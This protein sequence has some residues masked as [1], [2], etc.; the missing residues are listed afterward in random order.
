MK[1]VFKIWLALLCPLF[2]IASA[3]PSLAFPSE[4][5]ATGTGTIIGCEGDPVS[6]TANTN[7]QALAE[8]LMAGDCYELVPNSVVLKG[9]TGTFS[10]GMDA[11]GMDEGVI[12]SNASFSEIEGSNTSTAK[13]DD[14]NGAGDVDVQALTGINSFDAASIE[15]SFIPK[16]NQISFQ[17]VFASEEYCDKVGDFFSDGMGVYIN[18]E[19]VSGP[20]SNNRKNMAIVPGTANDPILINSINYYTNNQ[21]YISNIPSNQSQQGFGCDPSEVASTPYAPDLTQFDG[22]T[23]VLTATQTV[24]PG[25]TYNIKFVVADIGD[26]FGASAMMIKAGSFVTAA[27]VAMSFQSPTNSNQILENCMEEDATLTFERGGDLSAA[28]NVNINVSGTAQMNVDYESIPSNIT[29]PAGM[30]SYTLPIK[31]ITDNIIDDNETIRIN[32]SPSCNPNNNLEITIKDTPLLELNLA[33]ETSCTSSHASI[34]S[35]V[36]GG[37]PPY[38]YAWST[39]ATSPNITLN[40]SNANNNQASLTVTDFCGISINQSI[41]VEAAGLKLAFDDNYQ[42]TCIENSLTITPSQISQGN[43]IQYQW[44]STNGTIQGANNT[45]SIQVQTAGEYKL[46]ITDTTN[47]C[48]AEESVQ[49]SQN[50]DAPSAAISSSSNSIT[51]V[52][53][54]IQLSA[55]SDIAPVS[56]EWFCNGQAFSN[57]Q[58]IT[59]FNACNYQ[60]IVTNTNTGCTA[61]TSKTIE[62]NNDIPDLQAN[63]E[64]LLDCQND[65]VQLNAFS[66]TP[67]VSYQWTGAN[68]FNSNLPNPSIQIAG[69]Y[70]VTVSQDNGCTAS[71]CLE[72]LENVDIPNLNI[73]STGTVLTCDRTEIA[74]Y[75]NTPIDNVTYEWICNGQNISNDIEIIADQ[76]CTYQVLITNMD[77]GCTSM[78]STTINDTRSEP[79]I[80]AVALSALDCNNPSVQLQSSSNIA[81]ATYEWSSPNG[82]TSFLQNPIVSESGTYTLIVSDPQNACTNSTTVEVTQNED[83]PDAFI[84]A[85]HPIINC[86][87]S[88]IVLST[89]V[90]ENTSYTWRCNNQ[91]LSEGSNISV[92][93]ACTYEL[94]ATNTISGCST[95]SS[96]IINE[97][98]SV[99]EL[100][101][102]PSATLITCNENTVS[103][104][105]NTNANVSYQWYCGNSLVSTKQNFNT[106][107]ACEYRLIVKHLESACTATQSITIN[108]NTD[109]PAITI[110]EPELLTCSTTSTVLNTNT[111]SDNLSYQWESDNGFTSN[112]ANPTIEEAGIYTLII[113]NNTT[114]CSNTAS[115]EVFENTDIV[116]L[117]LNPPVTSLTCGQSSIDF[118]LGEGENVNYAWYCNNELVSNNHAITVDQA[119]TYQITLTNTENNCTSSTS[120][121]ITENFNEPNLELATTASLI[122]CANTSVMLAAG[123]DANVSYQWY[124]GDELVS[125]EQSFTTSRACEYRLVATD[126]ENN[127]TAS[128]SINIKENTDTPELLI[129]EPELLTCNNPSI[130][131]NTNINS[132]DFTYKWESD[133]GFASDLADPMIEQAGVYTLTVT[134]NFTNCSNSSSI[135]VLESTEIP[136]ATINAPITLLNCDQQ[137]LTLS[138]ETTENTTYAWYCNN[139]LVSDLNMLNIDQA[140]TYELV[141]TNTLSACSNSSSITINENYNEPTLAIDASATIITCSENTVNLSANTDANVSYAW[142]CG[143]DLVSTAKDFMA[144]NACEYR[145]VISDLESACTATQSINIKANTATPEV[146]INTPEMLT[147]NNTSIE[148]STNLEESAF[149]YEWTNDNG[150][151]SDAANPI[152][153]Q[154]GIYYVNVINNITGCS[155]T[156][157]IEVFQTTDVPNAPVID[158]NTATN[159]L[160]CTQ[161]SIMLSTLPEADLTYTWRCNNEEVSTNTS[162]NVTQACTY[163]LLATNTNTGCTA[164]SSTIILQD[165][166]IPSVEILSDATSLTCAQGNIQLNAN[167]ADNVNYTW[168]CASEYLSDE[169]TI[170][171]NQACTYQ[172][173]VTNTDNGCTNSATIEIE[174]NNEIP[175]LLVANIGG[176]T[177]ENQTATLTASSSMSDLDYTWTSTNGF[178][179]NL[180]N[181]EITE[182]GIYTVIVSNPQSGCSNTESIEMVENIEIPTANIEYATSA[183]NCTTTSIDLVANTDATSVR[184]EWFCGN[185]LVSDQAIFSAN[186]ACT[187]TLVITNIQTGCTNSSSV[188]II[189]DA[190]IPSIENLTTGIVTCTNTDIQL[191]IAVDQN[192]T[193]QWENNNGF[194]SQEANPFVNEGGLYFVTVTNSNTACTNTSEIEI[195]E[196]LTV[197][198]NLNISSS[199]ALTCNNSTVDLIATADVNGIANDIT[200]EWLGP[201]AYSTDSQNTT[202][203]MAGIYTV[204]ASATSGCTASTDIEITAST[205]IPSLSATANGVLDCANNTVALTAVTSSNNPSFEWLDLNTNSFNAQVSEAGIYTVIVSDQDTGCENTTTVEVI[206]NKIA[207]IAVAGNDQSINCTT[208]SAKLNAAASSSLGDLTY[209]WILDNNTLSNNAIYEATSAGVYTLIVTNQDNACTDSD[210]VNVNLNQT[211]PSLEVNIPEI[212]TCNQSTVLLESST[213]A[214][215]TTCQWTTATTTINDCSITAD[216]AGIYT[217]IITDTDN[218]CSNSMTTMV[219]EDSAA[220]SISIDSADGLVL[221]CDRSSLALS[222][223]SNMDNVSYAWSCGDNL[224]STDKNI[225]IEEACTYTL[226]LTDINNGCSATETITI[227]NTSDTPDISLSADGEITCKNQKVVLTATS[228]ISNALI[229][230]VSPSGALSTGINTDAFETGI[231]TV[232]ITNMDNACQNISE[233]EVL[234]NNT[235]P[236]A[237][238][239]ISQSLSCFNTTVLLDGSN[240]VG[241]GNFGLSYT[242]YNQ[243]GMLI[244]NNIAIEISAPDTYTLVVTDLQNGCTASDEITIESEGTVSNITF[245]G[246]TALTCAT[247]NIALEAIVENTNKN[248][249]WLGP[250]GFSSNN[251]VINIDQAGDYTVIITDLDSGCS[252]EKTINIEDASLPPTALIEDVELLTCDNLSVNLNAADVNPTANIQYEWIDNNGM[253]LGTSKQVN[254]SIAGVYT[255]IVTNSETA[256]S[257]TNAI[258]VMEDIAIPQAELTGNMLNCDGTATIAAIA[259]IP[260]ST[261][262]WDGPNGFA[263]DQASAIVNAPGSYQVLVTSPNGC[264]NLYSLDV[265]P[266]FPQPI[267]ALVYDELCAGEANGSIEILN[268][269][270]SSNMQWEGPDG[271]NASGNVIENLGVGNYFLTITDTDG[272]QIIGNFDINTSSNVELLDVIIN[273]TPSNQN[274][275]AISLVLNAGSG[276]ISSILWNNGELG[277]SINNLSADTYVCIVTDSYGCEYYFGP[278]EVNTN[279]TSLADLKVVE[280]WKAFPNPTR[281]VINLELELTQT[282][283]IQIRLLDVLG[284]QL[285]TETIQARLLQKQLDVSTLAAGIYFV[286]IQINQHNF[287]ERIMVLD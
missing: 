23:T 224:I 235:P 107:I 92:D 211:I 193:Y 151:S 38:F 179:S 208:T 111:N 70:C 29:I 41:Q 131:L 260:N 228:S 85:D 141:A 114:A 71:T 104:N 282:E 98:Y 125:T 169:P 168:Y 86:E 259:D 96:I 188:D 118:D 278:F 184:T 43:N 164:V 140:C 142:Y 39:G 4:S 150:F 32:Y 200:Y 161:N 261:F 18:G 146:I 196:N 64:G 274:Q 206:E 21:L 134:N 223:T 170:D 220:P 221:D 8:M 187:Y 234:E 109:I 226:V 279:T 58:N 89:E 69:T 194:S 35:T 22:F 204:I 49:V 77:N 190:A 162:L 154:A 34:N 267:N 158:L 202:V 84:N 51:C 80:N 286:E 56:Y 81:S 165:E 95:I 166:N 50:M 63:I 138:T 16:T 265:Q 218:G 182:A 277:S 203:S 247:S 7:A 191:N 217:V 45:P 243:A 253:L 133:N 123:S 281:N 137:A 115:I 3:L 99:P 219:M 241:Q 276:S 212:I 256:C 287:A 102:I 74:L 9:I 91:V 167:T 37:T 249:L 106:A 46:R 127:C 159:I 280:N 36:N 172:V 269:T 264:S 236:I 222:A 78:T 257:A 238:A 284:R 5:Y 65:N 26:P 215:N 62:S 171:I 113:T 94:I 198:E 199:N 148:L 2:F 213:D 240:S 205:D 90:A 6:Y 79:E 250:N 270:E 139:E 15:F 175:N 44:T 246:L 126:L 110:N 14:V 132:T 239:G 210:E 103:L 82:F 53:N 66:N 11:F 207:P 216:Q 285:Q 59:V 105:A 1:T 25:A 245:E 52:N 124:C 129:N 68:N 24:V 152:I 231:Y 266:Y 237:N 230:W 197:P 12:L 40:T 10:S 149:R 143:D 67:N 283:Q 225:T 185:E 176:L 47:G 251:C 189:E 272:C 227:S 145:L 54:E 229:E 72:V 275:G 242:W 174:A 48:F 252:A 73:I 76:A 201:N 120:I 262:H 93:Q 31:T 144:T 61:S 42:L 268:F 232:S 19:A 173:F 248:C 130:Q 155:K 263:T 20:F 271:F 153:E 28:L 27:D 30:A 60:V 233:I 112:I 108:E 13:G 180:Q 214:L 163:E 195:E 101:I 33:A 119:C 136:S 17:Y 147:C 97:T 128:K 255:L 88:S 117:A 258:E 57:Q 87:Q 121:T 186:Q 55:S 135:E 177:C 157:S 156:T 75:A 116:S 183:L 273:N 244:A 178:S 192:V 254:V 160:D 100:E 122:T 181:P 83:T 209:E